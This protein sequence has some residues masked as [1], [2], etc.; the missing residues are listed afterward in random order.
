[1]YLHSIQRWKNNVKKWIAGTLFICPIIVLR[2]IIYRYIYYI[3]FL[4]TRLTVSAYNDIV[5][6]KCITNVKTKFFYLYNSV[7]VQIQ[8]PI[9]STWKI[10]IS[11]LLISYYYVLLSIWFCFC[12]ETCTYTIVY[13]SSYIIFSKY[14]FEK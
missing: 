10:N 9:G 4:Y 11:S 3:L 8:L 14:P 2:I 1:M 13:Y 5:Y 12:I 7:I 6:L